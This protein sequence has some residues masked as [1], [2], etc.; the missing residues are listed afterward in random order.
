[1]NLTNR[2]KQIFEYIRGYIRTHGV[3][4]TVTEIRNH[5]NLRSLATVHKHLQALE[6]RK[7]LRRTKN[8]AR[9]IEIIPVEGTT[10]VDIPLLGLIAA[11]QP[12]AALAN[13]DVL[14]IPEDM[15]GRSDTYA[16]RVTG[17]SMIQDGIHDGDFIIVESRE[18]AHDGEIVVALIDGE[19]AT[20]KRFYREGSVIR[21]QPS[22]SEMD[23][24]FISAERVRI[25]GVVIGLIRKYRH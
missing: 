4:P 9:A 25:Q 8:C 18:Q 12:I 2:Q 15:M 16:L 22:N 5:F 7:C 6:M 23:P 17:N 19:D 10:S 13:P 11:G 14:T 20:V 3:A 21:L 24:I 1:M